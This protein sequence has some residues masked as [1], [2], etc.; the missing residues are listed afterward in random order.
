[1]IVQFPSLSMR[2]YIFMSLERRL[3]RSWLEGESRTSSNMLN[4]FL[5]EVWIH[6]YEML[7]EFE[8]FT[9]VLRKLT[10]ERRR[11]EK[12]KDPFQASNLKR[13]N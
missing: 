10:R 8:F 4:Q 5:R 12:N 3:L 11:Y 9:E 1:M 13:I 6:Q 7:I 2:I